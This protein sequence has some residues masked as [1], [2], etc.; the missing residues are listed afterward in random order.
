MLP[1]TFK[2]IVFAKGEV[3]DSSSWAGLG[4]GHAG[5]RPKLEKVDCVDWRITW[6][7]GTKLT[8]TSS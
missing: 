8:E 4:F 5:Y 3:C 2:T 6:Y 7:T 1:S